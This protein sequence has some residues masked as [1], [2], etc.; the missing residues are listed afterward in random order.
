LGEQQTFN[1]HRSRAA[2]DPNRKWSGPICCDA[3]QLL[4]D[5]ARYW[6]WS[7]GHLL[8]TAKIHHLSWQRSSVALRHEMKGIIGR[9][10]AECRSPV[11][12]IF[13]ALFVFAEYWSFQESGDIDKLCELTAPHNAAVGDPRTDREKLD[14]ICI[15]H[16]DD[17]DFYS[18]DKIGD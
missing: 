17:S 12:W 15:A 9:I 10:R 3:Q 6:F 2:N 16:K 18:F 13:F 1:Q 7:L 11:A 5:V 14:S 4:S 8:E